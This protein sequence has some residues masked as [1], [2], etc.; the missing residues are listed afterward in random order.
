VRAGEEGEGE[1]AVSPRVQATIEA[2]LA[3]LSAPAREIAAVAATIGREFSAGVL[4]AAV[5]LDDGALAGGLDELW[6][7]RIVRAREG[8]AYDFTHDRIREVAAEALGP[9]RRRRTHLLV[10][11]AL[12]RRH[13][14]DLD[15]VS[16]QV[17]THL[18]QAGA[19][20]EA[21]GWYAR[22][23]GVALRLPASGEAVRLL[24]RALGLLARLP[25]GRERDS[26]ELELATTALAPLA[27]TAGHGA[28]RLDE[29][30]RRAVT[31]A[32]RLG[33]APGPPLL[34]SVAVSALSTGDLPRSRAFAERL[35]ARARRD[36]DDV[37]HV[38]SDYVLGISAFWE[39]ELPAARGHF[40][41]ALARYRPEHRARHLLRFGQDPA[42]V[43]RSRL[44]IT[45]W[46]LGLPHAAARARDDA[47][48][49]AAEAGHPASTGTARVFVAILALEERDDAGLRAVVEQLAA[50]PGERE[51]E[52]IASTLRALEGHVDVLDGHPERGL[53]RV[54]AA[55]EEVPE[56]QRAP[57]HR[58]SLARILAEA[59]AV[60]GDARGGLAT[61]E[62]LLGAGDGVRL[63]QAEALR[64]RALFRGALGAPREDV[65][66]E[67]EQACAVARRQGARALELR[68]AASLLCH[69]VGTGDEDAPR[70]GNAPGTPA[71]ARCAP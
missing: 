15:P 37:L 25:A 20:E 23:A 65:D 43:C 58:A 49:L 45:L 27:M 28:P 41:A 52:V 17:A 3:R 35:R 38:E 13:A 21:V 60:A 31:L 36:A 53:A 8:E 32:D 22:A 64:L 24:E 62:L 55:L 7:R 46:F 71:G 48:A 39:G 51:P 2:R 19:T 61:V 44:A 57:G 66:A 50:H 56:V 1:D 6:R 63:W 70:A 16:G 54:R 30:Q 9:A 42:V 10:A 33:V 14:A 59:C 69:R 12:E 26:R 11:R 18:E 29:L 47:L 68:A 5:E 34:R 40:E 67:L 4:A